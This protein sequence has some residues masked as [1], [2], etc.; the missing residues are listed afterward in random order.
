MTFR[1]AYDRLAGFGFE[2]ADA[3][4]PPDSRVRV[5]VSAC[6]A[7]GAEP[8]AVVCE[9]DA[10]IGSATPAGDL[11]VLLD[12][13]IR[14]SKAAFHIELSVQDAPTGS[15]MRL[16]AAAEATPAFRLLYA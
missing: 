15:A 10:R 9:A 5:V 4:L 11:F 14:E 7:V 16:R 12:A 13:P 6:E 2:V 3:G 1:S 8:G